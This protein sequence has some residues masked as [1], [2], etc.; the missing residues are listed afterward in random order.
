MRGIDSCGYNTSPWWVAATW[1]HSSH[2]PDSK[3]PWAGYSGAPGADMDCVVCHDP[4]GSYTP[5]NPAG[6]PYAIRDGV[7][8]TAF[9]DDGSRYGWNG[10]PWTTFG[11]SRPVKVAISGVTVD[12][13]G[14]QGLCSACHVN[15]YAASTM[16]HDCGGCQTCHGHGQNYGENDWGTGPSH[17]TW[18][19]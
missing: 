1:T 4:H 6:N 2:G 14:T 7:D 8:G 13:G 17:N 3:R 16:S 5:S 11:V 10:P 18:C 9:V 15:W 12:W 19:P